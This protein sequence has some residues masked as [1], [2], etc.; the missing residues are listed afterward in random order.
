MFGKWPF[1]HVI[2]VV[3]SALLA[4]FMAGCCEPA[5]PPGT[6][7]PLVLRSLHSPMSPHPP[8]ARAA[9]PSCAGR[10]GK[11]LPQQS[12]RAPRALAQEGQDHLGRRK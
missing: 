12:Q 3:I 2:P 9:S 1:W 6:T 5:L 7:V 4:L 11:S 8:A 10:G